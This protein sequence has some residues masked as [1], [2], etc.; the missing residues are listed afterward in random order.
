MEII[1]NIPLSEFKF[2][3]GA[4]DNADDGVLIYV[5][6]KMFQV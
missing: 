6:T 1:I 5:K 4:R 2:L 3:G